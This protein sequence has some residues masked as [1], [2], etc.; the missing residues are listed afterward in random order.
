M[1]RQLF[2]AL[3]GEGSRSLHALSHTHFALGLGVPEMDKELEKVVLKPFLRSNFTA[4]WNVK[5]TRVHHEKL[6][7]QWPLCPSGQLVVTTCQQCVLHPSPLPRDVQMYRGSILLSSFRVSSVL[8][9]TDARFPA[10]VFREV[11]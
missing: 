4:V 2:L 6:V 11:F 3:R 5:V 9:C 7:C 8:D 10:L 1:G